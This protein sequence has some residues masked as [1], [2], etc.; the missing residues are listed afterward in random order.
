MIM[1]LY[2]VILFAVSILFIVI[3]VLI[4]RGR[5]DL[6]HDYH[7]KNVKEEDLAAYGKAFSAGMFSLSATLA[8]SGILA[9]FG[10]E[11]TLFYLSLV[12]LFAGIV[13]SVVI[14]FRVQKRFNGGMF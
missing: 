13:A 3:G 7:Q 6:I 14:L 11:K 2:S 9:L 5:T 4:Y 8:A 1:V 10:A 12:V